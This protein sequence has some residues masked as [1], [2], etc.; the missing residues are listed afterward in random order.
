MTSPS[1]H[2]GGVVQLRV[3]L[4]MPP[5]E[6]AVAARHL[7]AAVTAHLE[8]RAAS[9]DE[10]IRAADI[11]AIYGWLKPI[12]AN[13]EQHLAPGQLLAVRAA[14]SRERDRM[15]SKA[16]KARVHQRDG[17]NC[18][19][20]GMPVVRK[21]IRDQMR[22][23]YPMALRWGRKESEQH[24]AFQATWAQYDHVLPHAL[25]GKNELNNIVL[26]CAACNFGRGGYTLAEVGVQDPRTRDIVATSWDGLERFR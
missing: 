18:R 12:W 7:D 13:S 26:A 11:P 4:S 20:C 3:C 25:G 19:F 9:A 15:P 8:G 21:E 14:G 16:V 10:L 17:F 24:A 1:A 22:A 2:V 6:I 23:K 5:A